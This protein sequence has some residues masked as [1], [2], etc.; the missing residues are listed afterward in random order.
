VALAP[1][2][3]KRRR[4]MRGWKSVALTEK[5]LKRAMGIIQIIPVE[6]DLLGIV[7]TL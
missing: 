2:P 1:S 5:P 6:E 4:S 3:R 7:A